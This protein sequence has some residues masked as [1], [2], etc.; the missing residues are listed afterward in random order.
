[1][2]PGHDST[3][4]LQKLVQGGFMVGLRRQTDSNDSK[5]HRVRETYTR[6][7]EIKSRRSGHFR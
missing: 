5:H 3:A 1:M 7:H 6:I 4:L 2:Y